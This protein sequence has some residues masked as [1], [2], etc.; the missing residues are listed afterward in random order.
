MEQHISGAEEGETRCRPG[1]RSGVK[2][3][4]CR[5]QGSIMP[6]QWVS[7]LK[8]IVEFNIGQDAPGLNRSTASGLRNITANLIITP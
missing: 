8:L 1:L 3:S 6:S 4:L 5:F 7:K 2:K